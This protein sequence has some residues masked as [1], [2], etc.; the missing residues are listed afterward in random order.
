LLVLALHLL[1]LL[2]GCT[3]FYPVSAFHLATEISARRDRL[4]YWAVI[5]V[6]V[7]VFPLTTSGL[8]S[9]A[10]AVKRCGELTARDF[11]N[12]NK[13]LIHSA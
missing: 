5:T 3:D 2:A 6:A 12:G 13:L 10:G 8:A 4:N 1:G 7:A 11:A 9:A